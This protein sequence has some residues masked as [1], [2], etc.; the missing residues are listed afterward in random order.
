M[1]LG[2]L[3]SLLVNVR[4][5]YKGALRNAYISLAEPFYFYLAF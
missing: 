4:V 3:D 1:K 2:R 5:L